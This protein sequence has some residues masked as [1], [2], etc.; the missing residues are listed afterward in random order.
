MKLGSGIV[1]C[2]LSIATAGAQVRPAQQAP[3]AEKV[4]KNVKVLTGIPENQ[5]MATMGFFSAS[6]GMTCT[7]CHI[8]ESGGSWDRYADDSPLKV[9]SRSMIVMVN[10]INKAYFGGKR[11]VTCYSCHRGGDRPLVTPSIAELYGPPP[12]ARDPDE[13][14]PPA[15]KAVSADQVLDQYL[16]V[17]GGAQRL[18]SLT[19]FIAKGTY[20]G[21]AETEKHPLEIY[22]KAP[23]QRTM[24][25][26]NGPNDI[27]TTTFDGRAGWILAPSTEKPVPITDLTGGDLD[28]ARLDAE[29]SFPGRIKQLLTQWRVGFPSTIDDHDV[30]LV[31]GSMDG[32]YPVNLYFDKSGLLVRS[33]RYTESPVGLNPTQVDYADYREVAGIKMPFRVTTSWLDGRSV[34]ELT[35]VQPNVAIDAAKFARPAGK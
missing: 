2:V 12:P 30:Q 20:T 17:I 10:A 15:P 14:L 8:P 13:I 31:Q 11:E 9:R 7:D 19:S 5:F 25:V 6:L 21:Y 4:F 26:H 35:D 28:G 24:I 1:V 23:G 16:Q 18:A 3:M 33:V 29:L 32:R 22:A 34:V 27:T